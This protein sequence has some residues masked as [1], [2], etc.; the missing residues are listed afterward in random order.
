MRTSL[1]S[2]VEGARVAAIVQAVG[3]GLWVVGHAGRVAV[4]K[5]YRALLVEMQI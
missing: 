3:S 1:E 5:R 4:I 2:I